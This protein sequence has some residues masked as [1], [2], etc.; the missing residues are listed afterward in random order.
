MYKNILAMLLIKWTAIAIIYYVGG[1]IVG[2]IANKD[3]DTVFDIVDNIP[4]K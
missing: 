4:A 2:S 3:I 1:K